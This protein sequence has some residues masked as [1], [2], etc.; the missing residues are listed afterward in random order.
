VTA[1]RSL[2]FNFVFYAWMVVLGTL[3]LPMLVLPRRC[4][5]A[6]G[7]LFARNVMALLRRIVGLDYRI[8]GAEHLGG[9]PAIVA[10]K[11]QSAWDTLILPSL[12]ADPAV[13]LKRE[14]LLLPFYGWYAAKLG[15]IAID[16]GAGSR[17]LR[18][19]IE[20]ARAALAAGRCVVIFPQGTRTAPG[21]AHPYQPGVVALYLQT[22]VPVIPVALNSGLFWGRRS[23][24]KR[25]GTITLEVLQ[26]ILPGLDRK[27]FAAAL[28]AAI[29]GATRRLELEAA[30]PVDRSSGANPE[31]R[32]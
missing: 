29:E 5:L 12:L 6:V 15:M 16:R 31:K 11:H 13:V 14:L 23:F 26:P 17:A 20:R 8:V 28:E 1:L 2:L 24:L 9:G 4:A 3:T 22:G 30:E 32:G 19:L 25:P 27:R 7:R 18:G 10:I 21:A